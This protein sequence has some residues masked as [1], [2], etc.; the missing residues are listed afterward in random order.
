MSRT[1]VAIT[2]T[3]DMGIPD[4]SSKRA[5]NRYKRVENR[6]QVGSRSLKMT[7]VLCASSRAFTVLRAAH[8]A[9]EPHGGHSGPG[10]HR[11]VRSSFPL[12]KGPKTALN[13]ASR[14]HF[15]T[16]KRR[17]RSALTRGVSTRSLNSAFA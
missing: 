11:A 4:S 8:G 15:E 16:R 9:A 13:M 5:E 6:S 7:Q 12:E 2:D 3:Y 14:Y 10:L 1:R 17:G